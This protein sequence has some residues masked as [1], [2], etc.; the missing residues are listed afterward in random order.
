M[1][2]GETKRW[3]LLVDY[4]SVRFRAIFRRRQ[5]L[6]F[7]LPT[8]ANG[9]VVVARPR[10]RKKAFFVTGNRTEALHLLCKR[11]S[12]S[13]S[14]LTTRCAPFVNL[15][16]ACVQKNRHYYVGQHHSDGKEEAGF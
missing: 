1:C 3:S 14:V 10:G 15:G 13:L 2:T 5:A 16:L 8:N 7:K 6:N 11:Y 4:I 12:M 9:R